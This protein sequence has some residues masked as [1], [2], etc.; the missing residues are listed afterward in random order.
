VVLTLL[1]SERLAQCVDEVGEL[2]LH[3]QMKVESQDAKIGVIIVIP[4][5][6]VD[7][8][9]DSNEQ[10]FIQELDCPGMIVRLSRELDVQEFFWFFDDQCR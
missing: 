6:D 2:L 10:F 5:I 7:F 9:L 8:F 3:V 4:V 1:F